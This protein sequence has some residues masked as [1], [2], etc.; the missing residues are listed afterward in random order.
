LG[1]YIDGVTDNINGYPHGVSYTP[2]GS[3]LHV[4]WCWRETPS[5][6]TNHDL[7][8]AYSDDNGRIW[9]NSDDL[10]IAQLGSSAM[11]SRSKGL[12]VWNIG[13]NRGLINQEHMA[14][15]ATGRVH[16]LLSHMPDTEKDDSNFD[17]SRKKSQYFD[18]IREADGKWRRVALG[19][20]A[21]ANLR[22][23]LA[24]SSRYNLYAILPDLRIAGASVLDGFNKFTLLDSRDAGRFFSDPLIDTA[25]LL[26]EDKLSVV[27]P[28]KDSSNIFVLDYQLN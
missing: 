26:L 14:V 1:K 18:Y 16:V 19:L 15:D 25:R 9:K 12:S 13:Q 3:R 5:A 7:L 2:G 28:V 11:H 24:L 4:A 21:V 6:N 20:P 10:E 23:K 22:G 17:N 27:Y 8:Y